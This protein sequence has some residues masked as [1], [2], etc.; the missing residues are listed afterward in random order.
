MLMELVPSS[1]LDYHSQTVQFEQFFFF[2]EVLHVKNEIFW[3]YSNSLLTARNTTRSI[4]FIRLTKC[5][6]PFR[7]VSFFKR[8]MRLSDRKW[9]ASSLRST[10]F[11]FSL[12]LE[13]FEHKFRWFRMVIFGCYISFLFAFRIKGAN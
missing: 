10:Y 11:Y 8:L 3:K 13:V 7:F 1:F 9:L 4:C 5:T 12:K 6:I 2:F